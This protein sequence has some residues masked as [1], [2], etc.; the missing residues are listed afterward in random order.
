MPTASQQFVT[1]ASP[2]SVFEL[3][4]DFARRPQ[5]LNLRGAEQTSQGTVC[6]G[7]TFSEANRILGRTKT[8]R[9]EVLASSPPR[10]LSYR[11]VEAGIFTAVVDWRLAPRVKTPGTTVV[12]DV[13]LELRGAGRLFAFM[14]NSG[15]ER[16]VK[17]DMA[18][19]RRL[20]ES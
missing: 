18:A 6:Q 1:S 13:A 10:V 14:G 4:T 9:F 8:V 7:S 15:L 16:Q 5:W 19:L 3:L 20:L 11:S 12:I 2:E 17:R